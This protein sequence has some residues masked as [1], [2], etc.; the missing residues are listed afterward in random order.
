MNG[1][2]MIS[3]TGRS[4]MQ[5]ARMMVKHDIGRLPVLENDRIIGI[6]SRSDAMLYFYDLLP[7]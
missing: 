3:T 1:K 2:N 5:A 6:V 4:P 7:D